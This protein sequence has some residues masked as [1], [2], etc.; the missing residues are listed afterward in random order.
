MKDKSDIEKQIAEIEAEMTSPH[1]WDNKEQAQKRI[2]EFQNLKD[3]LAGVGRYDRKNATMT[4]FAGAGGDD[5]E[6]FAAM[7]L[8]IYQKYFDNRG[9]HYHTLHANEND[10]GGYRNITIE[11]VGKGVFG[12]L[13]RESGVHRLVRISP[14]N[15]N[16]KRHTSFAM[17]EVVP[18]FDD[19]PDF[20]IP[21]DELDI[22]FARSS[23]P[24]GQNVNKRET[25]VRVTHIPTGITAHVESERSQEQNRE[26]AVAMVT[27]KLYQKLEEE[28]EK[29]RAGMHVSKTQSVEWGNQIRSYVLHP[30]QMIKDHRT[31][32]EVRDIKKVFDDGIIDEFIEAEL[33][34]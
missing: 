34:L 12:T 23:G 2:E 7:L 4:I 14:F 5:A 32:V 19:I 20:S 8:S 26:K 13:K 6:D 10:H 29:E 24:G 9:W 33:N 31:G 28:K 1:F 3:E 15:A 18:I 22:K 30:Y 16:Q 27:S 25:S 17:V 11:I 21:P